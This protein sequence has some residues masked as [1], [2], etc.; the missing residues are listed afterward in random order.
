MSYPTFP[1][2]SRSP[3]PKGKDSTLDPTLRSDM[4]NGMEICRAKFTRERRQ[5]TVT[6][7]HLTQNDKAMLRQ[8]VTI[9]VQYGA[10]I[11]FFPDNRDPLN[12][13]N[14]MVR[15]SKLPEGIDEGWVLDQQRTRVGFELREV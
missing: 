9:T 7:E 10:G 13:Q 8:F 2:L 14:Y 5:W 15:F 4:E 3:A 6:L 1:E 12:P 11:F